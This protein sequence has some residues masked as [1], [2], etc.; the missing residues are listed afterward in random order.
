VPTLQTYGLINIDNQKTSGVQ[1]LGIPLD[2]IGKVNDFPKSLS[3][4]YTQWK[5]WEDGAPIGWEARDRL[6]R[7]EHIDSVRAPEDLLKFTDDEMRALKKAMPDV[8]AKANE[9]MAELRTAAIKAVDGNEQRRL[10]GDMADVRWAADLV[11]GNPRVLESSP[12]ANV[13]FRSTVREFLGNIVDDPDSRL[14][15][16]DAE[17]KIAGEQAKK[18]LENPSFKPFLPPDFYKEKF[19]E[20]FPKAKPSLAD[21]SITWPGIIMGSGTVGL[22]KDSKGVMAGTPEFYYTMPVTLTVMGMTESGRIDLGSGGKAER[23]YWIVDTSRTRVWQFDSNTV[24]V[25]FDILQTDLG[26]NPQ[27]AERDGKT[28]TI[29]GRTSEIHVRVKQQFRD[30]SAELVRIRDKVQAIVEEVI[31]ERGGPAPMAKTWEQSQAKWLGAIEKE[32]VLVT[33]LF[34]VISVVAIFL[35]FCIFYMIVVEKTRDIGIIK[36]VGATSSGVAG[37][38]LG[39]GAAIGIVGSGLGLL[40]AYLIV[41]NI[42][43]LHSWLGTAMGVQVW[44]PEVY[45]FDTIPSTMDPPRVFWIMTIA[46]VASVVGAL[47]PA[48]RAGRLNPVEALRWE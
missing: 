5:D 47:V 9:R 33:G 7:V 37:I 21:E 22:R 31:S 24:Y 19:L 25:P 13:K 38:F 40:L 41:H 42:N 43:E 2:R 29:P 27:T 45:A 20:K 35:I 23:S 28:I 11:G 17:R 6:R 48:I 15:P 32:L 3:R 34:A 1:V 14:K 44:D 16:N 12:R 36:S 10:A 18:G 46:I 26:M 4:Q 39:Y 8:A 30:S